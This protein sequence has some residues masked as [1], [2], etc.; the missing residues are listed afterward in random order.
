MNDSQENSI[1][2]TPPIPHELSQKLLSKAEEYSRY[3]GEF[4]QHVKLQALYFNTFR[5]DHKSDNATQKA[6]DAT[7]DGVRMVIL[8]LK[9]KALEKEMSALRTHLRLLENQARNLY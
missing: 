8:R 4:A 6:F 1:D 2:Q 5:G 3:S 7:E 9:L